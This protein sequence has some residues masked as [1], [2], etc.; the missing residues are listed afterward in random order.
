MPRSPDATATFAVNESRRPGWRAIAG[1][2][3]YPLL[4]LGGLTLLSPRYL[5]LL[6]LV[7]LWLR[8]GR[9]RGADVARWLTPIEWAVAGGLAALACATALTNSEML[10]RCYPVAVNVGLGLSFAASLRAPVSAVERIARLHQPDLPPEATPYLRNVTR[11]WIAFFVF[12]GAVALGTALWATR[13]IWA[14]YNGGIAYGLIGALF[15]G[16]WLWRHR[17]LARQAA[18][19]AT[20]ADTVDTDANA[21]AHGTSPDSDAASAKDRA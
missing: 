8:H 6:L 2:L 17:M 16:E 11:V 5:G 20:S 1:A 12:N 14:L 21:A 18:A 4:I 19:R 10:L 9:R 7:T 15:A 13:Q 3:A